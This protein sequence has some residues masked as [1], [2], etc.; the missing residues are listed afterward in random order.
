MRSAGTFGCDPG[1]LRVG[2]GHAPAGLRLLDE[3]L[4][5]PDQ[6]PEVELGAG[7]RR[8][9]AAGGRGWWTR[10]KNRRGDQFSSNMRRTSDC[11]A[12]SRRAIREPGRD[13]P[14]G[15]VLVIGRRGD[16][17]S[18]A[19]RLDPMHLAMLVDEGNHHFDRRSS[20]VIA[21][22]TD[23]LRRISLVWRSSRFSRSSALSR[24]AIW[25]GHQPGGHSRPRPS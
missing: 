9:G 8:C 4:P 15:P 19:D 7:G 13:C 24:S 20:S 6:A 12:S 21:K 3:A 5:G 2:T 11:S 10:S 1:V 25:W 16:P 14:L 23:A 18:A 22:Y 17:Q